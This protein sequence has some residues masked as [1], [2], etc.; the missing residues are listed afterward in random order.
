ME[1]LTANEKKIRR[2]RVLTTVAL[3][4]MLIGSVGLDQASKM[5][6]EQDLLKSAHGTDLKIYA[7]QRIP[8]AI[9]GDASMAPGPDNPYIYFGI[10]YVRN[11]GAAWGVLST[12]ADAVRIPFFYGLTIFAMVV[13]GYY[14]KNTPFHHKTARF[15][16]VLVLSG[17]LGNLI[18]RIRLGY[19]IDWLDVR[20]NLLGWAYNFP[21]FNLADS[22]ISLGVLLLMIDAIVFESQR[23]QRRARKPVEST[24][25]R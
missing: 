25:L 21:N 6:A 4:L 18:D 22:A 20:W 10:N 12:V 3:V 14:F 1:Q 24:T 23:L 17:A 19:V 15:A 9:I 5:H 8:L 7:G 11:Q 13:I 2:Y 16:L